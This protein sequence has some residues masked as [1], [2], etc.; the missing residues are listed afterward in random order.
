MIMDEAS[1]HAMILLLVGGLSLIAIVVACFAGSRIDKPAA[2][3]RIAEVLPLVLIGL[4]FSLT[5]NNNGFPLTEWIIPTIAAL[6]LMLNTAQRR[7]RF[8]ICMVYSIISIGLCLHFMSL[9]TS[10]FT[11]VPERTLSL[12]NLRQRIGVSQAKRILKDHVNSGGVVQQGSLANLVK[13]DV[14]AVAIVS[15]QR[16]WHSWL[17]RLYRV[18]RHPMQ[19]GIRQQQGSGEFE[20]ELETP[21]Q[22]TSILER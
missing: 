12:E 13:R 19:L 10:H 21:D 7:R 6:F 14:P 22:A 18:E 5:L 15:I 1:M 3:F 11:A 16:T 17:T 8:Q 9:I 20:I 2:P 4:L